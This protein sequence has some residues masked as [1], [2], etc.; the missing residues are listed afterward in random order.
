MA[1]QVATL[2]ILTRRAHFDTEV[3]RAIGDAIDVE[4][5]FSRDTFATKLDLQE[6]ISRL[7]CELKQDIA[8]LKA[9][10]IRWMFAGFVTTFLANVGAM[11]FML[12]H[13]R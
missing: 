1:V 2:D 11:Y 3:A 6:A 9:D 12:Q 8:D 4:M 5:N 10:M 7:R 13:M